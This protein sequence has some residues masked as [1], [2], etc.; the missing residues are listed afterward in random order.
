MSEIKLFVFAHQDDEILIAGKMMQELA[1]GN[2]VHALWC[3]DGSGGTGYY[4][5]QSDMSK[6]F[7]PYLNPGESADNLSPDRIRQILPLVRREE[8]RRA[9]L[10]IGFS[11]ANMRFL[12]HPAEWMKQ[13]RNIASLTHEIAAIIDELS[14]NEVFADAWEGA[15]ITHD[16]TNFCTVKAAAMSNTRPPVY[17]FPEYPL[18]PGFKNSIITKI[19]DKK[20]S[21][22]LVH[23]LYYSIGHFATTEGTELTCRLTHAQQKKKEGLMQYY[24]SQKK[25]TE[26]F[27]MIMKI[28]YILGLIIPDLRH[29]PDIESFRPVPIDRDYTAPPCAGH[30][31]SEYNQKLP[32]RFY[33]DLFSEA[34]KML[35]G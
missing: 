28:R 19:P 16:I 7:A 11:E 15:H 20:I 27:H 17:E 32:D 33:I 25:L 6:D 3:N 8:A 9:M 18:L 5:S 24:T 31:Y 12:N 30:R 4:A 10:S 29:S 21:E 2:E 22:T 35:A 34:R 1:A 13:P 14:P 23:F 26:N